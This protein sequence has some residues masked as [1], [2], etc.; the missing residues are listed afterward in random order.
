MALAKV[1]DLVVGKRH[2][3]VS[4]PTAP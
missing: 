2:K 1:V 4:K 3:L